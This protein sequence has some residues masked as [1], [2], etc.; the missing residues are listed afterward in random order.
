MTATVS[1]KNIIKLINILIMAFLMFFFRFIPPFLSMTESGMQIFGIFL[2]LV[3]GWCTLGMIETGLMA[4]VAIPLTDMFDLKSFLANGMGNDV[5]NIA[6]FSVLFCFMITSTRID[7]TL[8]DWLFSLNLI[9][10]KKWGFVAAI[11]AGGWILGMVAGSYVPL[12]VLMPMIVTACEKCG[13]KKNGRTVAW[14]MIAALMSSLM[15]KMVLPFKDAPL[16]ILSAYSSMNPDFTLNVGKYFAFAI[17]L[18]IVLMIILTICIVYVFHVDVDNFTKTDIKE[19]KTQ[20]K[21]R[22]NKLQK[23]GALFFASFILM[24]VVPSFMPDCSVKTFFDSIGVV[25]ISCLLMLVMMLIK[26]DGVP[27]FDFKEATKNYSWGI[28]MCLASCM[29]VVS[30]LTNDETG[31]AP[32]L[33]TIFDPLLGSL[34]ATVFTIVL[35]VL[36]VVITNFLN[37]VPVAL[38]FLP[39]IMSYAPTLGL[40]P[41]SLVVTL[42]FASHMSFATPAAS[43]AAQF[44]YA[45]GNADRVRMMKAGGLSLLPLTV[46]LCIGALL[47]APIIY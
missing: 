44:V 31:I 38:M 36:I 34:N 21:V 29:P 11:M 45:S 39:I 28:L 5:V 33:L 25:G 4:F 42:I 23:T 10:T 37:N 35:L 17:P 26:V 9:K 18:S 46:L 15:G 27:L 3:Y 32:S 13:Y 20:E 12:I 19:T 1:K 30:N 14:L 47:W 8:I 40:D 7:R 24:V 43:A 6:I 22:F 2:G 41:T 16:V